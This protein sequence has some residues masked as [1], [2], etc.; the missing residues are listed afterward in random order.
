MGKLKGMVSIIKLLKYEKYCKTLPIKTIN[1]MKTTN[2]WKQPPNK[3]NN[4]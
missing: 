4:K 1:K 2:K 3:Q